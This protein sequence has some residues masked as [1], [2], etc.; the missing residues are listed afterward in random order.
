MTSLT[1]YEAL[2]SI[3][4]STPPANLQMTVSPVNTQAFCQLPKET[5]VTPAYV[6]FSTITSWL[7][8]RSLAEN[9]KK[10]QLPTAGKYICRLE[11]QNN[12]LKD[13]I[14]GR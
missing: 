7:Y 3:D 2:N 10:Q 4:K 13:I 5:S 1:R 14:G 9:M 6:M 11:N 12:A 8:Q